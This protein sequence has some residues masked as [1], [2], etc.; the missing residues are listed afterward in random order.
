MVENR[1]QAP[2]LSRATTNA[3]LDLD[4]VSASIQPESFSHLALA[5]SS[6]ARKL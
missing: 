2:R 4:S 1:H 5:E 3:N 6:L